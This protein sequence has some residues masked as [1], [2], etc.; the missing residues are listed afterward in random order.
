MTAARLLVS[1]LDG[2][3]LGNPLALAR[4]S[5]WVGSRRGSIRLVYATGRHRD[6]A[7][8][9]IAGDRLPQPDAVISA[10]GT[11]IHD[12][13]GRPFG[14]WSDGLDRSHGDR[15]RAALRP[16]RWLEAQPNENQTDLKAS[17]DVRGM[18]SADASTIRRALT[19]AGVRAT[20]VYSGG[21]HL[22]VIPILTGKG[23]AARFLADA[24]RIPYGAV[25]TFG[26]SGNDLDLL[27]AGFRGTIVAN[28]LPELLSRAPDDVY[29]S[30][31]PFADGVLDGIRYWSQR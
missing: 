27:S 1:D 9:A 28:A 22:D 25:L 8:S 19:A 6:S 5:R 13:E 4:F 21:I 24:W 29:R 16:L 11:E 2:T 14:D 7:E 3:L 31:R 15:V 10:V 20:L 18:T 17:Y 12:G 23:H 30:A 26:D